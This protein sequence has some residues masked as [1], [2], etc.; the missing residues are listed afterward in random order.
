MWFAGGSGILFFEVV[1]RDVDDSGLV[2]VLLF[3]L[4]IFFFPD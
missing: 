2:F 4:E 3:L 1:F